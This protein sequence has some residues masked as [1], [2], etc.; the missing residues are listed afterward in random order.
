MSD[1]ASE[2]R[3]VVK[4]IVDE[5]EAAASGSLY[6]VDGGYVVIN[7]M[8]EWKKEQYA[9]KARKF[10]DEHPVSDLDTDLYETY[11]EWQ[12]DE[13]GT[14][15]DVDEPDEV[16]LS[17]YLEKQS[18]GDVRFEV[19]SSKQLLGGKVLFAYGGPN[20]WIHDDQ[21]CGYWGSESVEMSLD[22]DTRDALFSWFEEMWDVVSG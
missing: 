18:L 1:T 10:L 2:L 14:A 13:I 21:V 22:S 12:E 15:D 7:D 16:S 17:E 4:N 8:D 3:S 20:I 5:L 11:K 19:D 6:D 9:K